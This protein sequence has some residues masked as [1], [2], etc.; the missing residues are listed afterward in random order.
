MVSNSI[1]GGVGRPLAYAILTK[2][3]SAL[4]LSVGNGTVGLGLGILVLSYGVEQPALY[5]RQ[6]KSRRS[7]AWAGLWA[8]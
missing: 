3:Y 7:P 6:I 8:H 4:A 2:C 5:R 1:A